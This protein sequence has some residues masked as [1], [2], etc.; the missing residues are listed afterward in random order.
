MPPESKSIIVNLTVNI[1]Q[2]RTLGGV[3]PTSA[4]YTVSS[5]SPKVKVIGGN[6]LIKGS[7]PTELVFQLPV[8]DYVFVG[9]T[10]VAAGKA[11]DVGITE[12]PKIVIDRTP[13]GNSLTITDVNAPE[14]LDKPYNYILLLQ[15][16]RTGDIGLIDPIIINEP[17]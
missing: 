6:I 17:L 13:K 12:F 9:A 7:D 10:F 5:T 8:P 16:T 11:G 2:F 3:F 4:T 14:N 1:T 15:N